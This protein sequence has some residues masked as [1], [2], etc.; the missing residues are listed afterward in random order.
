MAANALKRER[1]ERAERERRWAEERKREEEARRHREEYDRKAKII[2]KFVHSWN[3][4]KHV[5]D[6]A[7]AL[8]ETAAGPSMPDDQKQE[9]HAMVDFA[10][11]HANY[12]DPL[13]DPKWMIANF[14]NP[15][16]QYGF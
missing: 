7:A 6:F 8:K 15:P 12:V 11:R 13:T 10:L 2:E 4:S 5:R 16:W 3:E 14:K 9:L 1:R